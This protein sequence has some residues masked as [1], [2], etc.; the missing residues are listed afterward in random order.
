MLKKI[1]DLER[2][3][4]RTYAYSVKTSSKAVFYE[5]ISTMKLK[6]FR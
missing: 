5:D 1:P 4:S 3:C 2:L 6:E